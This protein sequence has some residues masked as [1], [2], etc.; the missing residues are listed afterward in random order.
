LDVSSKYLIT[1]EDAVAELVRH[2]HCRTRKV[3]E[4]GVN[5]ERDQAETRKELLDHYLSVHTRNGL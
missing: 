1:K 3:I 5:R 4:N 2:G